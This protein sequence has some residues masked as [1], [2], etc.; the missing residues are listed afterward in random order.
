MFYPFGRTTLA[1]TMGHDSSTMSGLIE[2]TSTMIPPTPYPNAPDCSNTSNPKVYKILL[3]Y[4]AGCM[5][6]F[7]AVALYMKQ[8]G[9]KLV[10]SNNFFSL[11]IYC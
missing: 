1:D 4:T 9:L 2:H 8:I 11:I 5:I 3:I 6:I 10:L 7:I